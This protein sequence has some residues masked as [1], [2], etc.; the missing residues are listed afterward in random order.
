M[1]ARTDRKHRI[2]IAALGIGIIL[3]S[4]VTAS[5][6]KPQASNRVAIIGFENDYL[7]QERNDL[8]QFGKTKVEA[9]LGAQVDWLEPGSSQATDVFS[10]EANGYD[11]VV[12]LGQQSGMETLP[13]L[14]QDSGIQTV[15]LD[16]DS[17]TLPAQG[18]ASFVRYRVEEGSYICGFLA[19][20]LTGRND[21]PLT[22]NMPLC[23]FIGSLDDPLEPYYNGGFAKGVKA[24]SPNGGT[25]SYF[26]SNGDDSAK[27]KTSAE[28][29][30]KKG[31]DIIF[32]TPGAFNDA[33]INVAEQKNILLILVGPDRSKQS[34]D[35]ILT[36]LVLRDDNA[37]LD[38]VQ[39]AEEGR[40][41]AG[42]SMLGTAD[43]VWSLAPFGNQDV[44][45]RKE[46][47]EALTSQEEKV[48]TI[49]FSS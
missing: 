47:K 37:I 23:A 25:H 6:S 5:C 19:G 8:A 2:L 13:L 18:D 27:A 1:P 3:A 7:A 22:N 21:H 40:L 30:V 38:V 36:S 20:W 9:E 42:R 45:I 10:A 33:V 34:P 44:Y 35:H 11:L 24:A 46:L 48:S 15:A 49:D 17:Q 4:T 39:R 26:I 12:T 41:P 32:C 16:F 29:A 31:V 28:D 14:P 43:G